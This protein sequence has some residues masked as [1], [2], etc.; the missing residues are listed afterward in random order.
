MCVSADDVDDC[1]HQ[2]KNVVLEYLGLSPANS[3]ASNPT[4]SA[5]GSRASDVSAERARSTSTIY[6][7]ENSTSGGLLKQ[8]GGTSRGLNSSLTPRVVGSGKSLVVGWLLLYNL[9]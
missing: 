2:L 7:K 9:F 5:H 4:M 3:T 8:W 1:Y 6:D